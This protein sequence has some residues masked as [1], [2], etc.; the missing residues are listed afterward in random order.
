MHP[1]TVS[2][3]FAALDKPWSVEQYNFDHFGPQ[4]ILFDVKQILT[5]GGLEPGELAPDFELPR[6]GGGWQRL[7][8]LR[9]TP[10]LLH[11]GSFT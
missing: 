9:D 6:S 3:R 2:Q 11:F 1:P 5:A 8:A 4:H 10:T 7:S